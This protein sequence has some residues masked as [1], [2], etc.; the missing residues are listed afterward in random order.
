V[1]LGRRINPCGADT[2]PW[3]V[4]DKLAF[5][6]LPVRNPRNDLPRLVATSEPN[7][8]GGPTY[9][10]AGERKARA[11]NVLDPVEC[12]MGRSRLRSG[13]LTSASISL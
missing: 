13:R 8:Y 12:R 3:D 9:Y 1:H 11:E 7:D 10:D 4:I 5:P 6:A 2:R